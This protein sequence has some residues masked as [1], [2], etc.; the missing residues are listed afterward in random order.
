MAYNSMQKNEKG[1]LI[2]N[3]TGEPVGRKAK[4]KEFTKEQKQILKNWIEEKGELSTKYVLLVLKVSRPTLFKI[5]K[6]YLA[7]ELKW[8]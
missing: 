4:L 7:G 5:K 3:R 8:K 6:E 2:S 1:K